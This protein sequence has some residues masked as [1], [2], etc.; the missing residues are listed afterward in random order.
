MQKVGKYGKGMRECVGMWEGEGRCRECVEV[1]GRCGKVYW[2]SAEV[3]GKR[4]KVCWDVWK[5]VWGGV[6]KCGGSPPHSPNTSL[7]HPTLP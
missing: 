1:M 5:S 7:P 2:V 6:G 4:E 3:V